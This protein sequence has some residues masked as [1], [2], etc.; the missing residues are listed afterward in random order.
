MAQTTSEAARTYRGE[1][2]D[3]RRTKRRARLLE[4]GLDLLGREGWQATT[5]TAVC[6]RA[7]LTPRYFYESFANRDDL[8]VAIFDGVIEEITSAVLA[9]SPADTV[10]LLQATAG[11]FV[12]MVI[13]DPRKGRATFVE[14][15]G[16]EALTRRRIEGMHWFAKQLAAQARAG[17][18]LTKREARQLKAAS[19]I[20]SGGLVEMITAWLHGE[21]ESSAEQ[22]VDDYTRVCAAGLTAALA[23]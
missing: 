21:L 16:S 7:R 1:D 19:L 4:A 9:S 18:R 23:G 14:A 5:V 2:A 12:K 17:R 13:D 15:L 3:E 11:A 10:E 6:E 20:S 22:M 8:V